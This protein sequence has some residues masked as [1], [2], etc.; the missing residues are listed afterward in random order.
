MSTKVS[1]D[2]ENY[3]PSSTPLY[4]LDLV[5]LNIRC[6]PNKVP[7]GST[8]MSTN[9]L[10]TLNETALRLSNLMIGF[11]NNLA[12][13]ELV[14]NIISDQNNQSTTNVKNRMLQ[15]RISCRTFI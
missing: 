10:K 13:K 3:E 5:W 14:N 9:D 11:N 12:S 8:T 6:N 15:V 4:F 2:L 7:Y 1:L